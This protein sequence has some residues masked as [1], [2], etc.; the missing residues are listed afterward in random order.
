[1]SEMGKSMELTHC[2]AAKKAG[3]AVREM[4]SLYDDFRKKHC[5][6]DAL[7][8]RKKF[9]M[10]DVCYRRNQPDCEVFRCELAFDV[11]MYVIFTMLA[12]LG[13]WFAWRYARYRKKRCMM[14]DE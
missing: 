8:V 5:A 6:K 14:R 13:L 11:E 1:M 2:P 7:L 3:K 4:T 12:A 9:A 10:K